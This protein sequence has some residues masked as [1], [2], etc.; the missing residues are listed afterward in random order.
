[1]SVLTK[2]NKYA[3]IRPADFILKLWYSCSWVFLELL[4]IDWTKTVAF[5]QFLLLEII[6]IPIKLACI[7][8]FSEKKQ[9]TNFLILWC[10]EWLLDLIQK[11]TT[12]DYQ[13]AVI[14]PDIVKCRVLT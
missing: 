10:S 9:K 3:F 6:H 11:V 5:D 1:M 2:L 14:P 7:Y 4:F 8:N 12:R 13:E